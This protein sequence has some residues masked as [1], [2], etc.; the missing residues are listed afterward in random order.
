MMVPFL[1]RYWE[2]IARLT[3]RRFRYDATTQTVYIL[4]PTGWV[5]AAEFPGDVFGSTK[6]TG[7]GRETTDDD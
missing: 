5:A 7:V 4:N 1:L 3:P 2:P 6:K